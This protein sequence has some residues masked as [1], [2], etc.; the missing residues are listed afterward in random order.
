MPPRFYTRPSGLLA[1]FAASSPAE[2]IPEL[3]NIGEQWAP[4]AFEIAKHAHSTWELYLQVDGTSHWVSGR[5]HHVL[6]P[7]DAYIVAPE[8]V[9]QLEVRPS[10]DH[11]FYYAEIDVNPVLRRHAALRPVWRQAKA[12]HVMAGLALQ[13]PF[14]L[15]LD[16]VSIESAHRDLAI[17]LALD[18]LILAATRLLSSA[19]SHRVVQRHP[20]VTRACQLID[21]EPGAHWTRDKLA[22]ASGSSPSQLGSLFR[23][24][25]G[26][27]PHDYLLKRRIEL[28]KHRLRDTD[29]TVTQLSADLGFSSSQH[30]A[31]VFRQYAGV[32]ARAWRGR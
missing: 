11:H 27:S 23:R 13:S 26:T 32:S 19:P 24:E 30:F 1:G 4:A 6:A 5:Q 2:G 28:A 14:Q 18:Q 16:E 21:R 3:R 9:H 15:L 20:A 22:R 10:G 7:G 29:I 17:Q 31:R 12:F 8:I 25:L